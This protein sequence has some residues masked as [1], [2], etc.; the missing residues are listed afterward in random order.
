MVG[1]GLGPGLVACIHSGAATRSV[2]GRT[3]HDN[4]N[5]SGGG[6]GDEDDDADDRE[7]EGT[8]LVFLK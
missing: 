6:G 2:C 8:P 3:G 1:L 4:D 5:N 7:V